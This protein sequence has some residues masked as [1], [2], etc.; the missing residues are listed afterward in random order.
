MLRKFVLL[1]GTQIVFGG[2]L[3]L[4]SLFFAYV[5]GPEGKGVLTLLIFVPMVMET[6]FTLGFHLGAVYFSSRNE[7]PVH[8]VFGTVLF[9]V[10]LLSTILIVGTVVFWKPIRQV[11]YRGLPGL[12][13]LASLASV[14]ALLLFYYYDGLWIAINC[15]AASVSVRLCQS[16]VYFLAGL[17]LVG[18]F[19]QG[20]FGAIMAF[21]LGAYAAAALILFWVFRISRR[22]P[23][24]SLE[25]LRRGLRFGLAAYPGTLTDYT[26]YRADTFMISYLLGFQQIGYYSVAVPL[27]ELIWYL[28]SAMRPVLFA[29]TA[30]L[31]NQ[32]ANVITPLVL[33]G[34]LMMA[35]LLAGVIFAGGSIAFRLLLPSFAPAL[36][37]L[38]ILLA[39]TVMALIFQ[40]VLADLTSRGQ[41]ARA[42]QIGV[43]TLLCGMLFYLWLIPR[44]GIMGA[45]VAS[46]LAYSLQSAL[47]LAWFWKSTG[48]SLWKMLIPNQS[49]LAF[50]MQLT[51]RFRQRNV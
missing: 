22:W 43:V 12:V 23:V 50:V 28:T 6:V 21:T 29:R 10:I 26:L 14:P 41:G 39:A 27:A 31:V 35:C 34:T 20:V 44:L 18:F 51:S 4:N 2:T 32:E 11:V 19:K 42:S 40:L 1:F 25:L 5:L 33:R 47:S 8:Q 46:L 24:V 45:A 15:M 30:Q 9:L 38:A 16:S 13:V 7:Y 37:V 36:P 17:V 3:L 48:V 49:D